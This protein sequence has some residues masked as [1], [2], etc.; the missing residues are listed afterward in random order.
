MIDKTW[1]ALCLSPPPSFFL[2]LALSLCFCDEASRR[3]L[4]YRGQVNSTQGKE[5]EGEKALF[6][7]ALPIPLK[8]NVNASC[9]VHLFSIDCSFDSKMYTVP[10]YVN[11]GLYLDVSLTHFP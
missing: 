7:L 3:D 11:A 8:I 2:L 10:V 1:S 6:F 9:V 4:L 5:T